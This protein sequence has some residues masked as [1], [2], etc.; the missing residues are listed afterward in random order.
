VW[1]NSPGEGGLAPSVRYGLGK[2]II[3]DSCLIE[4]AIN[5]DTLTMRRGTKHTVEA[6]QRMREVKLGKKPSWETRLKM[7][8]AQ[9]GK[10]HT[11][12]TRLK[13]SEAHKGKIISEAQRQKIRQSLTGRVKDEVSRKKLIKA[14]CGVSPSDKTLLASTLAKINR[15]RPEHVRQEL[16]RQGRNSHNAFKADCAEIERIALE[17]GDASPLI[18]F[19]HHAKRRMIR[20]ILRK[21]IK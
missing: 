15:P 19:D 17:G 2:S 9:V 14:S 18:G 13:M 6:K 16:R 21:G 4:V 10:L 5:G 20:N 1:A 7:G 8:E 3:P 11:K 12:A